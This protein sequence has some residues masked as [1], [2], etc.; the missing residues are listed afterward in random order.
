MMPWPAMDAR[1][2]TPRVF[3]LLV[4]SPKLG[5]ERRLPHADKLQA[6]CSPPW[7][8]PTA[9]EKIRKISGLELDPEIPNAAFHYAKR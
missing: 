4:L 5:R 6:L 7:V 1:D 2:A 8:L 9:Y 3:G